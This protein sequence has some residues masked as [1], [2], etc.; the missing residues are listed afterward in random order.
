MILGGTIT[1]QNG[2]ANYNDQFGSNRNDN[3]KHLIIQQ[4]F[5]E[6]KLEESE[7]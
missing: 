5:Y 4:D 1:V 7:V 6:V 2:I 3:R